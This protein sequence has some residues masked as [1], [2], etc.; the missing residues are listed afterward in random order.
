MKGGCWQTSVGDAICGC[1]PTSLSGTS[2]YWS[3]LWT[4]HRLVWYELKLRDDALNPA[5]EAVDTSAPEEQ[6]VPVIAPAASASLPVPAHAPAA[7]ASALLGSFVDF[8]PSVAHL[9][10][11]VADQVSKVKSET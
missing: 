2:N 6:S 5:G 4:H 7:S 3:Y 8:M 11:P 10:A 9:Q 1:V